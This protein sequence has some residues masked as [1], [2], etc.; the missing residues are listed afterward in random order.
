MNT[1]TDSAALPPM[2]GSA[3][4]PRPWRK[5]NGNY[6]KCFYDIQTTWGKTH[7]GC[8]PNAGKMNA[9]DGTGQSWKPHQVAL[10]RRS[11]KEI[12]E[13]NATAQTP[14]N[15]GTKNHE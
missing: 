1:P 7:I 13:Q 14:P 12:P 9:T 2:A 11:I 5:W 15:S 10:I 3:S 4:W 6:Q 8:W